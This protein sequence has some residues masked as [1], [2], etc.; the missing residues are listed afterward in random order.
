MEYEKRRKNLHS[1]LV[2]ERFI[3]NIGRKCLYIYIFVTC[4]K[5]VI[6][7]D[8]KAECKSIPF[9]KILTGKEDF[10]MTFIYTK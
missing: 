2:H 1:L 7:K 10:S 6:S 5:A 3:W 9:K 4:K 8:I